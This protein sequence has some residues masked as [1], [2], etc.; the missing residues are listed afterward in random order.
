ML[1]SQQNHV[2]CFMLLWTSSVSLGSIIVP[3]VD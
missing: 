1:L 2:I 3:S